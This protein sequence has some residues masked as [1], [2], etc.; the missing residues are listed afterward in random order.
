MDMNKEDETIA[1]AAQMLGGEII[2]KAPDGT[3]VAQ[4]RRLTNLER[5]GVLSHAEASRQR[6]DVVRSSLTRTS[7]ADGSADD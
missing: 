2:D 4:L 1:F 5:E 6:Q 3:P 7:A